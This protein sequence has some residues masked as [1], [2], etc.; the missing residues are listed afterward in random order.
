MIAE[1]CPSTW[2]TVTEVNPLPAP[3]GLV[4]DACAGSGSP[5]PGGNF[6]PLIRGIFPSSNSKIPDVLSRDPA[7]LGLSP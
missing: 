2:S 3:L 7:T 1:A 5:V 4:V 6:L